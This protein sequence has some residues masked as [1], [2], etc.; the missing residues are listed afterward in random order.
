MAQD[1]RAKDMHMG[2]CV[3]CHRLRQASIDC[4]TCHKGGRDVSES[5]IGRRFFLRVLGA[6]G[7]AA[8]CSPAHAP[9]KLI[10]LL[11]PPENMVPGK[12][13]Q[14]RTVCRE[15]SAGCGVTAR[16]REGRVVKLEGNPEDPISGG[17]LCARGQAAVQE[18]YAPDRFRRPMMRGT[19]GQ[20][21]A[22]SWD[23]AI[24]KLAEAIDQQSTAGYQA[25]V[26]L[27]IGDDTP[28][29]FCCH[30]ANGDAVCYMRLTKA[31][32][33]AQS[34]L[35][36]SQAAKWSGRSGNALMLAT[37]TFIRWSGFPVS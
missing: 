22:V 7:V 8:G 35:A 26:P 28:A 2:F 19:D 23:A 9:E 14:Y 27:Q 5:G 33:P 10:P 25:L 1:V 11:V 36:R 18:L 3:E 34:P 29:L 32:G 12:P 31:L 20:L 15:C 4:V 13:L 16:S 21:V 24:A 30:P 17:A 37:R 6:T